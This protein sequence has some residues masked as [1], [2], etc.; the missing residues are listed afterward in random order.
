MCSDKWLDGAAADAAV[1]RID[2]FEEILCGPDH[3]DCIGLIKSQLAAGRPVVLGTALD[4]AFSATAA[5]GKVWTYNAS[6]SFDGAHAMCI[7]GYD[8]ALQAFKVRNS[9]RKDW[10]VNGHCWIGYSAF[11]VLQ[12]YPKNEKF[13]I[14]CWFL[15]DSHSQAVVDRLIAGP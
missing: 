13:P 6:K 12:E 2:G 15:W 14:Q 9:W 5:A 4:T 10:G 1:L 8:D 3:E 7:V 11:V